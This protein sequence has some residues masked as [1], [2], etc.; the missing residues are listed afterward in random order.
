MFSI[1]GTL[2]TGVAIAQGLPELAPPSPEVIP[3]FAQTIANQILPL[4]ATVV[5]AL[6]IWGLTE[7]TKWIRSKVKSEQ[8]GDA[9]IAA[10]QLAATT[11]NEANATIVKGFQEAAV[12]GKITKDEA[13][14]VKEDVL[15]QVKTNLP[16]RSNKL[17]S[18]AVGDL[19][20]YLRGLIEQKVEDA[21]R[22]PA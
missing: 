6:L 22:P 2:M 8:L 9:F 10:A 13:K 14:Q 4:L 20:A 15:G 7:F 19:D 3:T 16:E 17:L 11:V 12:D 1:L 5:S 18:E 21:K